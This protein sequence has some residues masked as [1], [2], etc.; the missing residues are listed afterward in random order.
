[1]PQDY[2]ALAERCWA[3]DPAARC[4]AASHYLVP[5]SEQLDQGT[6]AQPAQPLPY[7]IIYLSR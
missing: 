2:R 3:A 6:T 1:M 7:L 4:V 5:I